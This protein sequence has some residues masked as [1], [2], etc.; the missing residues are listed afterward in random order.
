[1]LK[2]YLNTEKIQKGDMYYKKICNIALLITSI[3]VFNTWK[4]TNQTLLP[5][6]GQIE[7]FK[8]EPIQNLTIFLIN[9]ISAY[10]FF[11]GFVFLIRFL[12]EKITLAKKII[13]G[14]AY[15]NGTWIGYYY[16]PEN[17][18]EPIVC[19]M[20]MEQDSE[21]ISM[22]AEAY[23][24]SDRSY[25]CTWY[26]IND[27]FIDTPN[28]LLHYIYEGYGK[29]NQVKINGRGMFTGKFLKKGFFRN[30]YR[31]DGSGFNSLS[32]IMIRMVFKKSSEN[33]IVM[34]GKK[35]ELINKAINFF[36]EDVLKKDG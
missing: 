19:Y 7:F 33:T 14:P 27:V 13:F 35:S 29:K 4:M 17:E 23:N 25:R 36:K 1:M 34:E 5:A 24:Y 10:G 3:F 9:S 16:A 20:M 22:N 21:R 30:P 18:I 32:A 26:S 8:N 12:I 2:I 11:H 15:F 31:I 6:I 28:A